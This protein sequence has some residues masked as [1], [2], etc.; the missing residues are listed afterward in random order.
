MDKNLD[1]GDSMTEYSAFS[2]NAHEDIYRIRSTRDNSSS[3][4]SNM[5]HRMAGYDHNDGITTSRCATTI[6][7]PLD[8]QTEPSYNNQVR[9]TTSKSF[10]KTSMKKIMKFW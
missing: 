8:K 4:G 3:R 5:E 1:T 10:L 6:L 9:L 7:P 2:D